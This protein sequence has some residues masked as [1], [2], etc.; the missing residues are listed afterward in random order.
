ME[1]GW[2]T[3]KDSLH[4]VYFEGNEEHGIATPLSGSPKLSKSWKSDAASFSMLYTDFLPIP[5]KE[6]VVSHPERACA[7]GS[8]LHVISEREEHSS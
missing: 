6:E 3:V 7:A 4:P 1:Y 2:R 8:T 5:K